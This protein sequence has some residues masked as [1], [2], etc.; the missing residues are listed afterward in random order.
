MRS[1]ECFLYPEPG[2]SEIFTAD[3]ISEILIKDRKRFKI[4][5][6]RRCFDNV[7]RDLWIDWDWNRGSIVWTQALDEQLV[8]STFAHCFDPIAMENPSVYLG[9]NVVNLARKRATNSP[10]V[11][12]AMPNGVE[13]LLVFS[14]NRDIGPLYDLALENCQFTEEFQACYGAE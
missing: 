2:P 11:C 6:S 5:L 12:F 14:S 10:T 3:S 8:A 1:H 7:Y 4:D 9:K 13:Q